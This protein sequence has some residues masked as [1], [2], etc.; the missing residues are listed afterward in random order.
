[1]ERQ[2]EEEDNLDRKIVTYYDHTS[3]SVDNEVDQHFARALS[4]KSQT[5]SK[6]KLRLL[7]PSTGHNEG[8]GPPASGSGESASSSPVNIR[9]DAM[10]FQSSGNFDPTKLQQVK[11]EEALVV[12]FSS[13]SSLPSSSAWNDKEDMGNTEN[14]IASRKQ[15]LTNSDMLAF[16]I[17]PEIDTFSDIPRVPGE[18]RKGEFHDITLPPPHHLLDN[19]YLSDSN[20]ENVK[21]RSLTCSSGAATFRANSTASHL[22]ASPLG[23]RLSASRYSLSHLTPSPSPNFPVPSHAFSF[24]NPTTPNAMQPMP[25]M[26]YQDP[27]LSLEMYGGARYN[28]TS[29]YPNISPTFPTG[30]PYPVMTPYQ[31]PGFQ[32]PDPAYLQANSSYYPPPQLAQQQ[33]Y[34]SASNLPLP[35]PQSYPP[36]A[37]SSLPGLSPGMPSLSPSLYGPPIEQQWNQGNLPFSNEY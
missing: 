10:N 35:V 19:E 27:D 4:S 13:L 17:Q 12:P 8:D 37:M 5:S 33:S 23:R 34:P 9:P 6:S 1:M 25:D 30:S 28:N 32:Y 2:E 16:S 24:H 15:M 7:L 22:P 20:M 18:S 36:G 3:S 29:Q 14:Q 11:S 31:S 26:P 21:S